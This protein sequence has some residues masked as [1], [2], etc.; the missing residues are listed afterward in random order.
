MLMSMEYFMFLVLHLTLY[1]LDLLEFVLVYI[2]HHIIQVTI[3]LY[4]DLLSH[5]F[6]NNL[7]QEFSLNTKK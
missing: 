3:I 7:Y 6:L 4:L 1:I 2:L 5:K